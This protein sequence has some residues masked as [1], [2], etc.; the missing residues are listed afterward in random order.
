MDKIP[1][2]GGHSAAWGTPVA[3]PGCG[4][5]HAG[6][7]SCLVEAKLELEGQRRRVRRA[8]R[9]SA[10]VRNADREGNPILESPFERMPETGDASSA[11]TPPPPTLHDVHVWRRRHGGD[12][13]GNPISSQPRSQ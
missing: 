9:P 8:L 6:G 3:G 12:P 7:C 2:N 11:P 10:V 1:V 4:A 5:G 13:R